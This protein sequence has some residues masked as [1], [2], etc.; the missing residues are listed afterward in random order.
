MIL[1][2][3][4][5]VALGLGFAADD[6]A[7]KI[8]GVWTTNQK[9]GKQ[10][11]ILTIEFTKDGKLKISTLIGKNDVKTDDKSYKVE[12]DK[13]VITAKSPDGS[14][15][16]TTISTIKEL[17]K[18]TMILV[19]VQEVTTTAPGKKSVT[20]TVSEIMTLKRK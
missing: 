4:M 12:K 17:T 19:Q 18:D 2:G 3:L 10:E 13:L 16:E 5:V 11:A 8:V 6:N 9:I 20:K 14:K 1:Q 15:D 7:E